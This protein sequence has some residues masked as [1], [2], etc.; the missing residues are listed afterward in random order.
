LRVLFLSFYFEPDLSA[1]SFRNT[2]LLKKLISQ[3][4]TGSSI[5]VIT[6]LPSRYSSFQV[7]AKTREKWGCATIH[8]IALPAHKSGIVDQS[9]AFLFYACKAVKIAE[10]NVYDLVYASSSRLMTASLGAYLARKF[11]APL[12]LDIRDIFLDTIKEALPTKLVW[13]CKPIFSS[14]EKWSFSQATKINI[15]SEGFKVYF[16][17]RYPGLPLSFH[18]NGIDDE[19]LSQPVYSTRTVGGRIPEVV[20][21]GNIGEGQGLHKIIPQLAKLAEGKLKFKIIG[22]GGRRAQLI[23]ALE[24][25]SVKNVVLQ[26]PVGR[27]ELI[28]VYQDADVLFM[29]LNDYEAFLKVLPS[30][31]FEYAASGK[32][33]WAGVAGYAASFVKQHVSNSA[34]FNPCDVDGA[35]KVFENLSLNTVPRSSFVDRFSRVNIMTEMA[36][37]ILYLIGA[38]KV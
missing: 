12:Y 18:T 30:K 37:D 32:P 15:V 10:A 1:G 3:A 8:R 11:N 27:A 35:I 31:V 14:V 7:E 24:A 38:P 26:K 2:A 34:V 20:Y 25:A 33:I 13:S 6:T 22:D 29:H 36:T 19:F 28:R 23:E 4:P 9:R 17:T 21:A 5:D 16:E